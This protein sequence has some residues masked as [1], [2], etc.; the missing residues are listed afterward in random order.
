[1]RAISVILSGLH[2]CV[3]VMEKT[4]TN[5]LKITVELLF[6]LIEAFKEYTYKNKEGAK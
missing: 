2:G 1:M 5:V 4:L 6:R 3:I